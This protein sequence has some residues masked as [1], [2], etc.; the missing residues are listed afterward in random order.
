MFTTGFRSSSVSSP[1]GVSS[2]V[3]SDLI[4]RPC[5]SVTVI[6]LIAAD[7]A[8]VIPLAKLTPLEPYGDFLSFRSSRKYLRTF[9]W[10]L[11][12]HWTAA[13]TMGVFSFNALFR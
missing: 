1:R 4:G 6:S 3:S 11:F 13:L 8:C 12:V 9:L 7:P 5:A 10:A 2:G